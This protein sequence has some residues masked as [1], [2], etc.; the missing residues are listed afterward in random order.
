[1]QHLQCPLCSGDAVFSRNNKTTEYHQCLTCRALFMNP[2][3][4][5]SPER[6]KERYLEHNNDVNDP[7]FQ[8]FVSPIVETVLEN[9]SP[10]HRGI[11][12]GSGIAPVITEMIKNKGF[13]INSYDPL[14]ANK[15]E[16]LNC[17][18]DYIAC[19]EVI[20]HF[21]N[22][23][24]EFALLRSLLNRNGMLICMT[25]LY[26]EEINFPK[27]YYKDDPTHIFFYHT[28]T[29]RWIK[30]HFNFS[31]LTINKRLILFTA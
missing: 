30:E 20:E 7:R 12:F 17:K 29:L 4:H 15:P 24:R 16:L 27:W 26:H 21:H 9:F 14:F 23:A 10:S 22:P 31:S 3:D 2:A 1:M 25:D 28:H 11:D 13:N 8:K 5:V 6:E 18:Y 19:C